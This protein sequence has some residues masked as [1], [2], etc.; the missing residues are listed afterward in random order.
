MIQQRQLSLRTARDAH[1]M[2]SAKDCPYLLWLSEGVENNAHDPLIAW[3]IIVVGSV[4]MPV[5]G[6]LVVEAE[7]VRI[8]S[9]SSQ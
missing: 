3:W 6:K 5:T 8:I 4:C 1:S 9:I 7:F 2:R